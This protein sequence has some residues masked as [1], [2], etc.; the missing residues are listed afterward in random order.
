MKRFNQVLIIILLLCSII[1]KVQAKYVYPGRYQLTRINDPF[2]GEFTCI[3]YIGD[4]FTHHG[5]SDRPTHGDRVIL[6]TQ[7]GDQEATIYLYSTDGEEE[8]EGEDPM[9][10]FE[11][12]NPEEM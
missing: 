8:Q 10:F 1:N 4:C 11:L 6:H 9:F 12:L 3:G 7:S 2:R 5:P